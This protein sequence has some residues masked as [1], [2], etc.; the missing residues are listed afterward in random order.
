[1]T[2]DSHRTRVGTG[3]TPHAAV[4]DL[5]PDRDGEGVEWIEGVE[6]F[7]RRADP[8]ESEDV[9]TREVTLIHASPPDERWRV[10]VTPT[11]DTWRAVVDGTRRVD[12]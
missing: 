1:M 2:T 8:S 4:T 12:H 7:S 10:V 11:G 5:L 9:V 3:T 6:A